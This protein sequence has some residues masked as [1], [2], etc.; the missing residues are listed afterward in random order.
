MVSKHCGHMRSAR[1]N[2]WSD[3]V[4]RSVYGKCADGSP[5]SGAVVVLLAKVSGSGSGSE[6]VRQEVGNVGRSD[7]S[8]PT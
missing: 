4:C 5:A 8:L 7:S 6:R 2:W 3:A 1:K